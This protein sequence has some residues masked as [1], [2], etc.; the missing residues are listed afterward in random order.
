MTVQD[1]V[2]IHEL[3]STMSL[4]TVSFD[5]AD[6]MNNFTGIMQALYIPYYIV[7]HLVYMSIRDMAYLLHNDMV[8]NGVVHVY[9]N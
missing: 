2:A 6:V 3:R 1:T 4:C 8:S 7:E 9:H 5:N